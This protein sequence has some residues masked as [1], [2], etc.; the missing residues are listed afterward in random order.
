MIGHWDAGVVN[1]LFGWL[2]ASCDVRGPVVALPVDQV[3]GRLVGHALPPHVALVGQRDVGEDGVA[4]HGAHRVGVGLHRRSRRDAEEPGLRVDRVQAT[5]LAVA[6]PADVVA[7]RLDLP[8]RDARLEHREVGLAAGARERRGQ[9]V[10]VTGR[11]GELQDQHVL[12]EPALVAGH[13]RGDPQREALLAQQRVAAVAGAEGPD[14]AGLGEVHDVL[15]LVARPGEVRTDVAI[16]VGQRVADGV[17]GG[18]EVAVGADEVQGRLAHA[19]HDP[20][21]D[22]DVRGVGDLHAQLG[23]R[24]SPAGPSRTGSRTSCARAWSPRTGP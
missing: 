23:D 10:D 21:V 5:V 18:H 6:H 8:A 9:V 24:A 7:D 14:L 12:G 11:A 2:E 20:H 3:R 1:R 17:H 22:H 16:P 19:G 4:P 13:R 15:D